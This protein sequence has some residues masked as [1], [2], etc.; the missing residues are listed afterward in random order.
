MKDK[1]VEERILDATLK[2]VRKNTISGTRMHL[3]ATE[4]DLPQA[5]LHYHYKTKQNLMLALHRK[6]I[7]RFLLLRERMKTE[8]SIPLTVEQELDIFFEQKKVS[9]LE[10]SD[11]D[12][13]EIDFWLQATVS[14]EY[15]EIMN[16]AFERWEYAIRCFIEKVC[17]DKS[18]SDKLQLTH[19]ILS[20]LEGATIQY[21]VNPE[22]FD[23]DAYFEF[24]KKSVLKLLEM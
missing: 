17:P 22:H 2:V 6:V 20:I 10:D 11:Y 16:K 18:E 15:R 19:L 12:I 24:G 7:D 4:A 23:V 14:E 21:H 13:V 1:K 8:K 5:N 9:I 3:I